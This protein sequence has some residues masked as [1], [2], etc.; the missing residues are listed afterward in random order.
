MLKL[1]DSSNFSAN[2]D[3]HAV[4]LN[5]NRVKDT[6]ECLDSILAQK[7]VTINITVVDN[8]STDNSVEEILKGYPQIDVIP[9]GR[10]L[11]YPGGMNVGIQRALSCGA[12]NILLLN[13]DIIADPLMVKVLLDNL[14][15]QIMIAAPLIYFFDLPSKVWSAGGNINPV[16]LEMAPAPLAIPDKPMIKTFFTGCALLI[17]RNVFDQNGVFD[18][19]YFPGYYEDLDFCL[20]MKR[21]GIKMVLVPQAKLWHKVSQSSGG[22]N[23]PRVRYLMARNSARYFRKN[24]RWWQIPVIVGYRL[25]SAIKTSVVLLSKRD[26]EGMNAYW[27][28]LSVGWLRMTISD[29][30]S[31]T[32]QPDNNSMKS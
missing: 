27:T 19:E 10:N 2:P 3:V 28:G 7:K 13:N 1:P 16:L 15:S 6:M 31:Y 20:R 11:G 22:S 17:K 21:A 12:S 23:S 30:Y 26:W 8:G 24:M 5:W 32:V 25:L 9:T 29:E 14:S 4:I 18:E